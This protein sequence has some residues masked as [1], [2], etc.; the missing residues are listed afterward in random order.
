[1]SFSKSREH[2]VAIGLVFAGLLVS[3]CNSKVESRPPGPAEVAT[4][5]ICPQRVVLT[6]ELPGRTSA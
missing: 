4:V 6:T 2:S 5:T 3:S 1:M